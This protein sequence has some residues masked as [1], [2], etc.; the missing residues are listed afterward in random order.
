MI[1]TKTMVQVEEMDNKDSKNLFYRAHCKRERP[2]L[3]SVELGIGFNI[4]LQT[5]IR[6]NRT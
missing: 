4:I 1:E 2:A 3:R 5:V 6:D